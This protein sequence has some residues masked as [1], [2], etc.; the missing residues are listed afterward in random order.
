[1]CTTAARRSYRLLHRT[2]VFSNSR[3][4]MSFLNTPGFSTETLFIPRQIFSDVLTSL[5]MW[6]QR[7][8]EHDGQKMSVS[9]DAD[10]KES[11]TISGKWRVSFARREMRTIVVFSPFP[12][13]VT[14]PQFEHTSLVSVWKG[15]SGVGSWLGDKVGLLT[16]FVN[17]GLTGHVHNHICVKQQTELITRTQ[18]RHQISTRKGGN[19]EERNTTCHEPQFSHSPSSLTL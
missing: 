12:T 18:E 14:E 16:H 7:P 11:R 5:W 6:L 4:F 8:M 9:S 15:N 2:S 1:M 3:R 13:V 10:V 19:F 17:S